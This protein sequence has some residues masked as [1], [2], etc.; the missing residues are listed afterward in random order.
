MDQWI[1]VGGSSGQ[2]SGPKSNGWG[3]P[4]G[5]A[6]GSIRRNHLRKLVWTLQEGRFRHQGPGAHRKSKNIWGS[7]SAS[8]IGWRRYANTRL[9]CG[10]IKLDPPRY[11]ETCARHGENP[12]RRKMGAAWDDLEIDGESKSHFRN[13]AL[14]TAKKEL[15][16]YNYY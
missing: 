9:T 12:K 1:L 15:S 10:D 8:V 6:A 16:P 13:F 4:G 11:L 5:E 14:H 7:L 3:G 2:T